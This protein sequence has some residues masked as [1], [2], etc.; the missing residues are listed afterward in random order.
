MISQNVFSM[1]NLYD[2]FLDLK[3]FPAAHRT[4]AVISEFAINW[5]VMHMTPSQMYHLLLLLFFKVMQ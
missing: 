2:Y 4:Q 1:Y 3:G 5:E